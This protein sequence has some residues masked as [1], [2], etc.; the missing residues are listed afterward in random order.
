MKGFP[1]IDGW[2]AFEFDSAG[3]RTNEA[4]SQSMSGLTE[5]IKTSPKPI[6]VYGV[7]R[8]GMEFR[9]YAD[10]DMDPACPPLISGPGHKLRIVLT[11]CNDEIVADE[12]VAT[13]HEA[14]MLMDSTTAS[15]GCKLSYAIYCVQHGSAFGVPIYMLTPALDSVRSYLMSMATA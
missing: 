7:F 5:H 11:D 2:R 1:G 13:L 14:C 8:D 12:V 6:T 3:R 4:E 10:S 15:R 9:G